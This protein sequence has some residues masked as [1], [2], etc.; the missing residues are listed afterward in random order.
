MIRVTVNDRT[1][2]VAEGTTIASLLDA[3]GFAGRRIA[4]ECNGDIVP[5]SQHTQQ[6][7]ADGDRLEIVHAIGGG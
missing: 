5:R 1:R 6:T 4:V 7:L 3:L 2:D